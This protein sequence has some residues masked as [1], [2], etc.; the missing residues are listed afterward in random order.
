MLG[1]TQTF[2]IIDVTSKFRVW[3]S[4]HV[5]NEIDDKTFL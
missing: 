1:K 3:N 5:W 4:D 2:F